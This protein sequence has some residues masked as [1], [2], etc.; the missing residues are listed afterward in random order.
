MQNILYST[1]TK[2]I[3]VVWSTRTCAQFVNLQDLSA[4]MIFL[5]LSHLQLQACKATLSPLHFCCMF[6]VHQVYYWT[7]RFPFQ[8]NSIFCKGVT[9]SLFVSTFSFTSV[10]STQET[11][12]THHHFS[13]SNWKMRHPFWVC[14]P[15]RVQVSLSSLLLCDRSCRGDILGSTECNRNHGSSQSP[16]KVITGERSDQR[17]KCLYK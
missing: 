16:L 11:V 1:E 6:F 9:G 3:W 8:K 14:H 12:I 5:L 2:S 7:L 10:V 4:N 13:F 17:W 15:H